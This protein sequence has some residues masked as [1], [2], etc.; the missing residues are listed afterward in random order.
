[1]PFFDVTTSMQESLTMVPST[2]EQKQ[3][4]EAR[5]IKWRKHCDEHM[6]FITQ[7]TLSW[8]GC[9]QGHTEKSLSICR[10]GGHVCIAVCTTFRSVCMQSWTLWTE[11]S[12][13]KSGNYKK[14]NRC[15][16]YQQYSIDNYKHN[17]QCSHL[18]RIWLSL[19]QKNVKQICFQERGKH[20]H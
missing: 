20:C 8:Y 10:V 6:H 2:L 5:V 9:I 15:L 1:M 11:Y 18:Q 3:K 14:F 16:L 17:T 12:V 4:C 19:E 7:M 13:M